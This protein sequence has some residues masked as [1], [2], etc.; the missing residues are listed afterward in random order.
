[1]L[2]PADGK[3]RLR[4]ALSARNLGTHS[5]AVNEPDAGTRKNQDNQA[6]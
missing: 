6:V 4:S 1:M 5:Q 2:F 3:M